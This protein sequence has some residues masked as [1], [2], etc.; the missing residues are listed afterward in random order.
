MLMI[1]GLI[2]LMLVGV[3]L[4][5]GIATNGSP[6]D[7]D[8]GDDPQ[9]ALLTGPGDE[10]EAFESAPDELQI[11]TE[12]FDAMMGDGADDL[13]EGRGGADDLRGGQGDDTLRGGDGDD[14]IQGESDYG[15]GGDDRLEGGDGGDLLAGQ[16]GDD[17][18][19]GGA[20]NDSLQGGDGD[21]LLEGGA[22]RDWIDGGAGNDRLVSGPGEDDLTGGA[23][24]DLLIGND[25]VETS[26]LH[27]GAGNDT[28]VAGAGDFAEG[29]EG[30]DVYIVHPGD[31]PLPVIA[32]LDGRA[33]RLELHLPDDMASGAEIGL[34][35]GHDGDLLL[36]VNGAA[37]ARLIGAVNADGLHV[38]VQHREV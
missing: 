13:L 6:S 18:I 9:A 23:G 24:D 21:D 37:V 33:D 20:G 4:D 26:W 36:R 32:G 8:E 29:Q 19:H 12:F 16:G 34:A 38:I 2:G 28:L 35:D 10:D 30:N 7:E 14:W 22:G 5:L 17:T 31:G 3:A 15:P 1:A 25:G 27:G 11:G